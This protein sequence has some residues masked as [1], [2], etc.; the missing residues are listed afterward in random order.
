MIELFFEISKRFL[1]VTNLMKKIVPI[2]PRKIKNT[3]RQKNNSPD[4]VGFKDVKLKTI[5]RKKRKKI[6]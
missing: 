2:V 3:L 4:N 6:G 5:K 1:A